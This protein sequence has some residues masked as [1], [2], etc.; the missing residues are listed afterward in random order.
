MTINKQALREAAQ[1]EIMLRS[2][3]DTS[4]AWQ[5]EA[6]PEAVLALL[7][8]LETAEKQLASW[9]SLAKQNIEEHGKAVA[10]LD[11]ARHRICEL[12]SKLTQNESWSLAAQKYIAEL[13]ERTV[14]VKQFDDFQIVHYGATEDYANGY[15]DCQNNYNKALTAAG[16]C[17]KGD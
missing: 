16:I 12:E 9:R 11:T 10:A 5:D 6:S 14:V 15:I 13:E 3:S 2:V 4:D 7:D 1:E 8:E 17:V